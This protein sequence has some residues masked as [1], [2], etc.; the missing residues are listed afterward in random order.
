MA[1][2]AIEMSLELFYDLNQLLPEQQQQQQLE[3]AVKNERLNLSFGREQNNDQ[4]KVNEVG[5]IGLIC[6]LL[7]ES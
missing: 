5:L 6:S 1:F 2:A 3:D 7:G 4:N